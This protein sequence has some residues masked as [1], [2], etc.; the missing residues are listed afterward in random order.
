MG[1]SASLP[2]LKTIVQTSAYLKGFWRG[3]K[4]CLKKISSL[5]LYWGKYFKKSNLEDLLEA[6]VKSPHSNIEIITWNKTATFLSR[7]LKTPVKST[8]PKEIGRLFHTN[9]TAENT[10]PFSAVLRWYKGERQSQK[11]ERKVVPGNKFLRNSCCNATKDFKNRRYYFKLNSK[12][13]RKDIYV[14]SLNNV[15]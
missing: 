6:K 8:K 15:L 12:K 11:A 14:I 4:T 9:G 3:G 13:T 10:V 7:H 2:I 5:V 1:L